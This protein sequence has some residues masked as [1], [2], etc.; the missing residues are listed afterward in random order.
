MRLQSIT[1][2]LASALLAGAVPA[3]AAEDQV[4]VTGRV[5]LGEF[6]LVIGDNGDWFEG[7]E[8]RETRV[9]VRA[10]DG[11]RNREY[12]FDSLPAA[13]FVLRE[14]YGT[15]RI[16]DL[17]VPEYAG[18]RHLRHGHSG[19]GLIDG[20]QAWYLWVDDAYSRGGLPLLL[21]FGRYA[22]ALDELRWRDGEIMDF[23]DVVWSLYRWAERDYDRIYWRGW[24]DKRWDNRS[25]DRVWNDRWDGW[26]WDSDWGW[27]RLD[28]DGDRDRNWR[29]RDHYDRASE[30]GQRSRERHHYRERDAGR[31]EGTGSSDK[32]ERGERKRDRN[33]ERERDADHQGGDSG[34]SEKHE[35][36]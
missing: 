1:A 23:D 31:G 2:L 36:K 21:A 5:D 33:R 25:W 19:H 28:G 12:Y 6:E 8:E 3:G 35:R 13:L 10:G 22:D 14:H 26:G 17:A 34:S 24:D 32:H 30:R 4:K 7:W 15:P 18:G 9:Y 20:T 27:L 11:R 29:D 16:L